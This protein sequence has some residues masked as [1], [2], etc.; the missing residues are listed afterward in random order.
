M[1]TL[2]DL[3]ASS[4]KQ[5]ETFGKLIDERYGEKD[6][7]DL[8][9]SMLEIF[10]LLE[11]Y[12][13]LTY[14]SKGKSLRTTL[15]YEMAK[16]GIVT[17]IPDDIC[18]AIKYLSSSDI[19]YFQKYTKDN[20]PYYRLEPND[21]V[22]IRIPNDLIAESTFEYGTRAVSY[23][24]LHKAGLKI[25]HICSYI[26]ANKCIHIIAEKKLIDDL[27]VQSESVSGLLTE[28]KI[29]Q[30]LMVLGPKYDIKQNKVKGL[31]TNKN[32]DALYDILMY[33]YHVSL[34][35]PYNRY[36]L[37][38]KIGVKYE[39]KIIISRVHLFEPASGD[40]ITDA[41]HGNIQLS[42]DKKFDFASIFDYILHA[43]PYDFMMVNKIHDA[44]KYYGIGSIIAKEY[45]LLVWLVNDLNESNVDDITHFTLSDY[46]KTTFGS[47]ICTRVNQYM[48]KMRA[49]IFDLS[50]E[51]AKKFNERTFLV[52][53]ITIITKA[54]NV[55]K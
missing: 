17:S 54:L 19:E 39:D 53:K 5:P 8:D 37:K 4:D 28:M 33:G 2:L 3:Y 31:S 25:E 55:F 9:K 36:I 50:D 27:I 47:Y 21:N 22:Y 14:S 1:T 11:K 43:Y 7:C 6:G 15:L 38:R 45:P 40:Y 12:P 10:D 18:E 32:Y 16:N 35:G 41:V 29:E 24:Y 48:E 26:A 23:Q 46:E 30:M 52:D 49:K 13:H 44:M 20:G 51:I 34:T 42:T